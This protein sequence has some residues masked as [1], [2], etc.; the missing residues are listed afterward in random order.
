[1]DAV[2]RCD[3]VI[4]LAPLSETP[5]EVDEGGRILR[6][7]RRSG[8]GLAQTPQ[9]FAFPPMLRAHERA[10]EREGREAYEYTDDA[11][12]WGEFCGSVA[13]VAGERGNRKITYAEDLC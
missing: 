12:V 4:P 7:L 3:A 13:T 2:I 8:L 5:K 9:A 1:M 11:E 6:H 10:A